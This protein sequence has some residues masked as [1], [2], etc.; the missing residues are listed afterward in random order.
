M[1][2]CFQVVILI[3]SLA[4]PV[5]CMWLLKCFSR[6]VQLF[7]ASAICTVIVTNTWVAGLVPMPHELN[8]SWQ[9][10]S[11]L[12][13]SVYGGL[14]NLDSIMVT[15]FCILNN[16]YRGHFGTQECSLVVFHS[17][18]KSGSLPTHFWEVPRCRLCLPRNMSSRICTKHLNLV[19][20]FRSVCTWLHEA[21]PR[22]ILFSE[23]S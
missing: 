11:L 13:F 6:G 7:R 18:C 15:T 4:G 23:A 12:P 22:K 10:M 14:T 20:S 9:F 21:K 3:I 19:S 5:P 1:S 17:Y 8:G 2:T 16:F